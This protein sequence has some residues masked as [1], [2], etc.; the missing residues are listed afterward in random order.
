M[1]V[2]GYWQSCLHSLRRDI[3]LT[4]LG[5]HTPLRLAAQRGLFPI[6]RYLHEEAKVSIKDD[7]RVLHVT[8]LGHMHRYSHHQKPSQSPPVITTI[9]RSHHQ[10]PSPEAITITTRITRITRSHY[11]KPSPRSHH[12]KPSP[13]AITIAITIAINN[14]QSPPPHRR[15]PPKGDD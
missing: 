12:Q 15:Q 13:E 8:V 14:Q 9:N 10:K 7:S 6:V 3:P 2:I 11:Q 5:K 4:V 1:A